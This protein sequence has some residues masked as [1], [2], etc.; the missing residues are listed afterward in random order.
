EAVLERLI[1]ARLLVA[2]EAEG[3][4][5]RIEV[6]HEALLSAW[7]R[8]VRWRQEDEQGARL[9]DQLRTAARQWEERNHAKG[10]LWRD[11]A[12]AEYKLWRPRYP[13]KL[14]ESEEKFASSS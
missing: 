13:G 1:G 6:V 7:P 12:L 9:R 8:L 14:T 5:E 2:L 4:I 3:G 10:L 11:E